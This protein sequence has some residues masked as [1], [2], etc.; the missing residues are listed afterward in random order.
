MN[1][2]ANIFFVSCNIELK[3][4]ASF[5]KNG[6]HFPSLITLINPHFTSS[7]HR[8]KK[9]Q[10]KGKVRGTLLRNRPGEGESN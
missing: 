6:Y 4:S 8:A 5:L 3:E 1:W 9:W 7:V 2:G 10:E